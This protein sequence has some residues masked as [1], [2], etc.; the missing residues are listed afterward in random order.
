MGKM[1]KNRPGQK[2]KSLIAVIADEDTVT[3]FLLAG[4]GDSDIEKGENFLVVDNKTPLQRIEEFFR[5]LISRPDVSILLISQ[6]VAI[7]IRPLLDS[8]EQILPAVLEIPSPGCP[9][10]PDKDPMMVRIN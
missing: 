8:Y 4:V 2:S 6:Q 5:K 7:D 10:Q 3:G 1:S 9:Y